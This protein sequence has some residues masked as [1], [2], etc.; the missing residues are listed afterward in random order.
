L[1]ERSSYLTDEE[2][3]AHALRELVHL[4][5]RAAEILSLDLRTGNRSVLDHR[6]GEVLED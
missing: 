1:L 2:I 4:D 6:A 3:L 5:A